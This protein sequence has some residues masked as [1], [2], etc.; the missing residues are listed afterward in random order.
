MDNALVDV[1]D[2][3]RTDVTPM[4][5]AYKKTQPNLKTQIKSL[6]NA[7][8]IK[9]LTDM[10]PSIYH[11]HYHQAIVGSHDASGRY[12]AKWLDRKKTI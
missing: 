2:F 12:N 1:S 6:A 11:H 7:K 4:G 3:S 9:D 5:S 8:M 10:G